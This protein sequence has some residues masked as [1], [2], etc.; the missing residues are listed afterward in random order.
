MPSE[1]LKKGKSQ[2]NVLLVDT[3]LPDRHFP[4]MEVI[5]RDFSLKVSGYFNQLVTDTP[6]QVR[7][8]SVSSD[9]CARYLDPV[10]SDAMF[11]TTFKAENWGGDGFFALD[12]ITILKLVKKMLGAFSHDEAKAQSKKLPKKPE[13]VLTKEEQVPDMTL[14]ERHLCKATFEYLIAALEESFKES[15]EASFCLQ[16]MEQKSSADFFPYPSPSLIGLFEFSFDGHSTLLHMVLPYTTLQPIRHLLTANYPGDNMG[17][18]TIWKEHVHHEIEE[19]HIEMSVVLGE[20][21]ESLRSVMSWRV[22]QV[23]SL[24]CTPESLI[25]VVTDNKKLFNGKMG[26]KGGQLAMRIQNSFIQ[27]EG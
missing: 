9:H 11:C 12:S 2:G 7:C 26:Q 5:L 20:A 6:V 17:K 8:K 14:V 13:S 19:S 4:V 22:G 16:H 1:K 27:P 24:N 23:I 18:D 15:V 10:L 25:S 21:Y 3:P